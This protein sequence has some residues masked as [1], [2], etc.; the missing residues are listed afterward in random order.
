[1]GQLLA[2]KLHT[3]SIAELLSVLVRKDESFVCL[4]SSRVR[5][6]NYSQHWSLNTLISLSFT[7]RALREVALMLLN[8]AQSIAIRSPTQFDWLMQHASTLPAVRAVVFGYT[9]ADIHTSRLGQLFPSIEELCI[10]KGVMR[11]SAHTSVHARLLMPTE[12][13]LLRTLVSRSIETAGAKAA[14]SRLVNAFPKLAFVFA[15][16][17][18]HYKNPQLKVVN[19]CIEAEAVCP[20][21]TDFRTHCYH[22]G[23]RQEKVDNRFFRARQILDVLQTALVLSA[24]Q[25]PTPDR[26][27]DAL[28]TDLVTR[29]TSYD[30]GTDPFDCFA[31]IRAD[32]S[33]CENLFAGIAAAPRMREVLPQT[34]AMACKF[35]ATVNVDRLLVTHPTA[36]TTCSLAEFFELPKLVDPAQFYDKMRPNNCPR[37]VDPLT[38]AMAVSSY[39]V[40]LGPTDT[41]VI[42][43]FIGCFHRRVKYGDF[44]DLLIRIAVRATFPQNWPLVVERAL[45]WNRIIQLIEYCTTHLDTA[46]LAGLYAAILK[47][48]KVMQTLPKSLHERIIEV[49]PDTPSAV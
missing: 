11:L 49:V 28:D 24:E 23:G 7:N 16:T 30:C 36:F 12:L 3:S 19:I 42:D 6:Y 4:N 5:V 45:F 46:N 32:E 13:P 25:Q 41:F 22:F 33:G 40:Q 27:W 18:L 1:M 15:G 38:A 17:C 9:D 31:Y 8:C 26:G 29:L 14:V 10:P 20:R 47:S 39:L 48:P 35:F 37:G 21:F 43:A 34:F 44:A 2:S